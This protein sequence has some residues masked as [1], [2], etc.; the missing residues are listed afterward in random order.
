M[1]YIIRPTRLEDMEGFTNLRRMP[2]VFETTLGLPSESVQRNIDRFKTMGPDNHNFVA[3]LQDGTIIGAAALQVQASPR[4]RHVGSVGIFVHT[5]YQNTGVGTALLTTLL[6]LADNWLMLVRVE[7][8]V[9]AD[10]ERAIR[11]YEKLG[12]EKEGLKR[13]A[14]IRNGTYA[15]EYL[16]ARL[17]RRST[18]GSM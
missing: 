8:E 14:T 11:L 1:D 5:D 2:G 17:K 12:F 9:F 6:D 15:D 3:V 7:L 13:M 4:M 10:N 16:M 18:N